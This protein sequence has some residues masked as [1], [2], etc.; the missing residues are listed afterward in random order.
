MNREN[1]TKEEFRLE[2][3]FFELIRNAL[4]NLYNI[5]EAESNLG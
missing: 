3:E 1:L 5:N 2:L 4:I